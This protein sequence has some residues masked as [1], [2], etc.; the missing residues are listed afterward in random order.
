MLC[1][2]FL[3]EETLSEK[4]IEELQQLLEKKKKS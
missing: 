3:E 1:A 2:K 4:D